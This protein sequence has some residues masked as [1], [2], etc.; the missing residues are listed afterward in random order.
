MS[1]K[2][3]LIVIIGMIIS[4]LFLF[5]FNSFAQYSDI[6]ESFAKDEIEKWSKNGV[7]Q[8]YEGKFRP[9]DYIT[10]GE[11]SVILNRILQYENSNL[12][13]DKYIDIKQGF[14]KNDIL[15]LNEQGIIMGFNSMLRPNDKV[16]RQEVFA[17]LVRAFKISGKIDN[18]SFRDEKDIANWAKSYVDIIS[19]N[20]FINGYQGKINPKNNI[21]R[22]EL[23]K[24][25]DN[26]IDIYINKDG[27]YSQEELKKLEKPNKIAIINSKN[28]VIEKWDT[29]KN[30][31]VT[32]NPSIEKIHFLNSNLKGSLIFLP[33]NKNIRLNLEETI[34][35]NIED[36]SK[37]DIYA[38]V[39]TNI[40]TADI[41]YNVL[42]DKQ[43]INKH[44]EEYE[45]N[46]RNSDEYKPKQ[47]N[48]ND[49]SSGSSSD[50][51]SSSSEKDKNKPKQEQ[52][53]D[54]KNPKDENKRNENI[55]KDDKNEPKAPDNK[56]QKEQNKNLSILV[57]T[58]LSDGKIH[59]KYTGNQISLPNK[60]PIINKDNGENTGKD[61]MVEFSKEQL[62]KLMQGKKGEYTVLV[63][64][65]EEVI[66]NEKNY[67]KPQFEVVFVIE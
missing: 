52:K 8:G 11:L 24:I 63:Q 34:I 14:Y 60:L 23:V 58:L 3:N 48:E 31:I 54:E 39:K 41:K 13:I 65:L 43:K 38:D 22:A 46:P 10:R 7:I 18:I 53:E 26:M 30:I 6:K 51:S 33:R 20:G 67:E 16:T 42:E 49:N 62:D 4:F 1:K 45:K 44:K 36:N 25:L 32:S 19:S 12:N 2:C 29:Q 17:I 50:S 55:D 5:S 57:D 47:P 9:D 28:V 21:K 61:I 35:Q 59:I 15:S 64:A 40:L 27:Y 56:E 37:V 66:I